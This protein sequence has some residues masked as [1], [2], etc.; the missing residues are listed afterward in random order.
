MKRLLPFA[1]IIALLI[2]TLGVTAPKKLHQRAWLGGEFK[3]AKPGGELFSPTRLGAF[4]RELDQRAGIYVAAVHSETPLAASGVTTGDLLLALDGRPVTSLKALRSVVE[5]R[6]PGDTVRLSV[7]H[8]G[9][10]EERTATLGVESFERSRN[11]GVGLML[12]HKIDL[13]PNPDFS[14]VALGFHHRDRRIDLR[15]PETEFYLRHRKRKDGQR[16]ISGSEGWQAWCVLFSFG[17]HK[18]IVS[19]ELSSPGK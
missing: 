4:P 10:I 14:A 13:V 16:G 12:S 17:S 5:S 1:V 3:L 18:Q 11:I 9:N 2:P 8:D 19:Q 15:S 6:D 7:Y